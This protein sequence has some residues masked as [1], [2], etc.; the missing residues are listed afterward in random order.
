MGNLEGE[1]ALSI[2][3]RQSQ[4]RNYWRQLTCCELCLI[5]SGDLHDLV[6]FIL[7]ILVW[8]R[9]IEKALLFRSPPEQLMGKVARWLGVARNPAPLTENRGRI[10]TQRGERGDGFTEA[11]WV[12]REA[13][14]PSG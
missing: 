5:V 7:I 3:Q 12:G 4:R 9:K 2:G 13:R 8:Y 6:Y 14:A 11:C 10:R 1:P